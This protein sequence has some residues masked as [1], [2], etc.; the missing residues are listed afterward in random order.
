M[1][2]DPMWWL[3]F[4]VGPAFAAAAVAIDALLLGA[5][6]TWQRLRSHP[7]V[8]AGVA[9]STPAIALVIWL[10][11]SGAAAALAGLAAPMM[12]FVLLL[13]LLRSVKQSIGE[14]HRVA[15][16]EALRDPDGRD[17]AL[18]SMRGRIGVLESSSNARY[19][20]ALLSGAHALAHAGCWEELVGLAEMRSSSG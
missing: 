18:E 5:R 13:L 8:L 11:P 9:L 20:E 16:V 15:L 4:A 7:R 2:G 17:A 19:A 6:R 10:F 1:L 12:S 3:L 14:R